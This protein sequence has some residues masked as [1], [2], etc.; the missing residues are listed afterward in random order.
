MT[1]MIWSMDVRHKMVFHHVSISS[2][3]LW[4]SYNYASFISGDHIHF[5]F[6]EQFFFFCGI[7]RV[8]ARLSTR[9]PSCASFFGFNGI[10]YFVL[11]TLHLSRLSLHLY[12]HQQPRKV[13]PKVHM[14]IV[15]NNTTILRIVWVVLLR[16]VI[17]CKLST[18]YCSEDESQGIDSQNREI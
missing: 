1:L 7:T 12:F 8:S 14:Y 10:R 11:M 5:L 3:H 4:F 16:L 13:T 18:V 17:T 2:E 15:L 9:G 6:F